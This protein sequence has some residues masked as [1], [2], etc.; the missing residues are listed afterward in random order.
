MKNTIEGFNQNKLLEYDLD[1]KDAMILRYCVDFMNTGRMSSVVVNNKVYYWV[2]YKH[3]KEDLPI[4]K[5]NN[6]DALRKRFKKLE[7]A[8]LIEHHHRKDG[9]SY[10]Y[11]RLSEKYYELITIGEEKVITQ[12]LPSDSE[13]GDVVTESSTPTDKSQEQNNLS[14]KDNNNIYS[15]NDVEALWK[16]YPNKKG[17]VQAMKRICKILKRISIDELRR[18][19]ERYST[20]VEGKDKQY[21]LNGSTYFNGRYEDYL[22]CNYGEDSGGDEDLPSIEDDYVVFE[23]DL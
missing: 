18:C 4:L 13:S 11:Y 2:S 20:E 15:A 17:K 5:I 14:T 19:I 9:G 16:L 1:I 7:E 21:I 8:G 23:E 10:S 12:E 3:I 22:D 6:N